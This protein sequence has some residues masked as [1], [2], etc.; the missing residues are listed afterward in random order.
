MS[1]STLALHRVTAY[2]PL[3]QR[4]AWESL[5]NRFSGENAKFNFGDLWTLALVVAA[6]VGF[7]LLL[8]WLQL[9]QEA[10]RLSDDP[11]HLFDDLCLAHRLSRRDRHLLRQ[12]AAAY[13]LETPSLL[14]VRPDLFDSACQMA[15]LEQHVASAARL[16]RELFRGLPEQP[17]AE[18]AVPEAPRATASTAVPGVAPSGSVAPVGLP[19]QQE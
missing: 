3:A 13:H 17:P 1:C 4:D 9:R 19:A 16:R 8:R 5:G 18:V 15:G 10:R 6:A 12:L 11:R 2:L 7:I 14:F